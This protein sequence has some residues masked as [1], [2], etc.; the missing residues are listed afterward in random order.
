MASALSR[1]WRLKDGLTFLNHGS[2]GATPVLV[3]EA[4]Q[5]WRDR[6]EADPVKFFV[7][8]HEG[9]M[10]A[11]RRA[12]GEFL[13]CEWDAFAPLPNA[14]IAVATVFANH[15]LR[16]GDEVLITSHE[17]PACQ[18]SARRA[19]AA[20]GASVVVAKLPFPVTSE[21]QVID[22]IMA[23]VT[24][25][26]KLAMLSHVTSPTGLVLPVEKLVPMLH[27]RGVAT[28]IDGAHAPGMVPV[29]LGT[30]RPTYYTAN[31]HKWICSPKG[32]AFL[33]VDAARREGFRPLALSNHAEKPK[34]GRAQF[35]TEFE[36]VGTQDYTAI[37]AIPDA[38]AAMRAMLPGGWP[39]VMRHN[40]EL[41]IRGRDVICEMLG[42]TPA[43]PDA[44]LGSI[45]SMILPAHDEARH[46]RVMARATK[47][48]D[49][50]QDRLLHLHNIQV[51]VWGV[52]GLTMRICRISAQVYN[53]LDEYERLGKVLREELAY[54]R[55]L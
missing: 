28:L 44:M 22:A 1:H 30:L 38:I 36:Y 15:E 20:R 11:T 40:H 23:S 24:S 3:Q 49:A 33:Y 54:E 43:A 52:A 17:Y 21:Q 51:P 12:L 34:P 48:H 5:A 13:S 6:L 4:Q 50:L 37:Y 27:A 18:N 55:G 25:K 32:S 29:N 42:I 41:A 35:L 10:D 47:Y 9:A 45:V 8:D 53:S 39:A 19:A 14:S 2:F 31:C 7:E 16:T 26:T 46:A